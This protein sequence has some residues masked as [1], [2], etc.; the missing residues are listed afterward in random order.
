MSDANLFTTPIIKS[1]F[2]ISKKKIESEASD[3]KMSQA[4][5]R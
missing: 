5:D 3:D 1:R 2:H 4:I